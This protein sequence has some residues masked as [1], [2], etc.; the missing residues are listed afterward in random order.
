MDGG[1]GPESRRVSSSIKPLIFWLFE[2]RLFWF[3]LVYFGLN[4][5]HFYGRMAD[6]FDEQGE[7]NGEVAAKRQRGEGGAAVGSEAILYFK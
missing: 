1:G 5:V 4:L 7:T 6:H 3:T 2:I